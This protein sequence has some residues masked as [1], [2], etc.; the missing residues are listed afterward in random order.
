MQNSSLEAMC[1]TLMSS[2]TSKRISRTS[3]DA[4]QSPLPYGLSYDLEDRMLQLSQ[5]NN[6]SGV[7][8]YD[9]SNQLTGAT[10]SFQGP[11]GFSYDGAGNR[12][13]PGY[14]T[15]PPKELPL[16]AM[17]CQRLTCI[18]STGWGK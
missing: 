2:G 18:P 15:G 10:H 4:G 9:R 8:S 17:C 16:G 3:D 7:Y 14:T 13:N 5:P 6:Q 11:E 1:R 12:T